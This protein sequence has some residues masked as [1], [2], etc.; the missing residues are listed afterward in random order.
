[1]AKLCKYDLFF[2]FYQ[3]VVWSFSISKV[4]QYKVFFIV[5][6]VCLCAIKNKAAFC[7]TESGF[8]IKECF[9]LVE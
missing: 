5:M 6:P 9:L 8:A 1:M 7:I 2:I 3:V 4:K